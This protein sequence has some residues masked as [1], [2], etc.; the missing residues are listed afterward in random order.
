MQCMHMQSLGSACVH[1]RKSHEDILHTHA[2]HQSDAF[3]QFLKES[4]K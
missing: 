3:D 4:M 1:M 2:T